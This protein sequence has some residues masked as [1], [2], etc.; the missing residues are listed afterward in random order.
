MCLRR[1]IVIE[2]LRKLREKIDKFIESS[3]LAQH[4]T[5]FYN[6]KLAVADRILLSSD[7]LKY[8]LGSSKNRIVFIQG[9]SGSGKSTLLKQIRVDILRK[10]GEQRKFEGSGA[11]QIPL[12]AKC[13]S[14]MCSSLSQL[15]IKE[16]SVV[17]EK[18]TESDLIEGSV[19]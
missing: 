6:L 11:F 9:Q 19:G 4:I 3:P 2:G 8:V 12:L 13:N 15:V 5:S 16:F 7:I 18:L 1:L 17:A 10:E 14:L